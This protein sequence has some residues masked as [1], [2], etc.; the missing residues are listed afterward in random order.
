M[1]N[2]IVIP[3]VV[4]C[5]LLPVAAWSQLSPDYCTQWGSQG[6]GQ[7]QFNWPYGVAV[8]ASG[9][10]YVADTYNNRIQKFTSSGV[11]ITRWGSYGDGPG[12][13]E[14]PYGVAVDAPGYVYIAD[15]HNFRIQKFTSN[16]VYIT[17]WGSCGSAPAQFDWPSGVA[18]DAS[19]NVYVADTCNHRV[20]IFCY[21]QTSVQNTTWGRIKSMFR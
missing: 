7:G 20:Q 2:C 8:D 9:N 17:R 18:V 13:F 14:S 1:R 4:I 3:F 15:S 10:V 21:A 11:Y 6:T 16:G 5:A 19:G 12:Q